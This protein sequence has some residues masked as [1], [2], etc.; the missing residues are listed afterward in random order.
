MTEEYSPVIAIDGPSGSGKG[1]ICGI[2]AQRLEWHL[3]DS[4]ALYRL[5]ALAAQRHSILLDNEEALVPLAAHLDVEFHADTNNDGLVIVLEGENV[6]D[7]I[8]SE[9]CSQMASRVAVIP[10]VRDALLGRQR[11]FSQAPGLVADGRDMGSVVFPQATLKIFL[12][13]SQ[14]IRAERRYKQLIK[15][16]ISVNFAAILDDI[17]QRDNRD[18]QRNV[19]PLHAADDAIIVDTSEMSIDDVVERIMELFKSK[20]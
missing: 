5:V 3:L 13:A 16:G 12:T 18:T 14:K 9:E 19:S 20:C 1:T 10:S 15:K 17:S 7:A 4:G 2:I 6:T 8:R 11:A